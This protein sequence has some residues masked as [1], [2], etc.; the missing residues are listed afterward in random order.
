MTARPIIIDC[1][2]G[3][4]D[5]LAL[6]LALASPE[7]ELLGITA[8]AGNVALA[9]TQ[10]N[11]RRLC[12]V[13]GRRDVKVFAGCARPIVR[14]PVTAEGVHGAGG[15]GGAELPAPTMALQPQHAVDWIVETLMEAGD[16][17]ITL[18]ALGP[19]TNLAMAIVKEPRILPKVR[20]V[21][22][23]GGSLFRGGNVTPAAE[24][25]IFAD[26]HAAHVV[27]TSGCPLTLLPLDVTHQARVTAERFE[28]LSAAPTAVGRACRELLAW[29]RRHYAE[30]HESGDCPLH[31]PCVIAYLLAPGLFGGR[32]VHVAIE[33]ASE[34]ALGLTLADWRGVTGAAPNCTVMTE[35]DADA[36]FDLLI[37]RI[38]SL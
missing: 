21:V 17:N 8:V 28:R 11:A 22:M 24:F 16:T 38:G 35:I 2:P 32:L 12:E 20:E 36:F 26:P 18:C 34:A 23:M 7:L 25:N 37:G 6:F 29:D 19:L 33:T 14:A 4:D 15:L 10:S 13:A 1:D 27:F 31:D 30:N 3:L 9:Q 5:A